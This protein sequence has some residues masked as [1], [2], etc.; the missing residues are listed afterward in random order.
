MSI[1]YQKRAQLKRA[2]TSGGGTSPFENGIIDNT[3]EKK[4]TYNFQKFK[5]EVFWL[6]VYCEGDYDRWWRYRDQTHMTYLE[7]LQPWKKPER[8]GIGQERRGETQE[9]ALLAVSDL[10]ISMISL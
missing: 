8:K 5:K 6:V 4:V 2:K 1:L 9:Q 10:C 7:A 3:E